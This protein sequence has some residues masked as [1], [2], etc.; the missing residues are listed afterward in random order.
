MTTTITLTWGETVLANPKA[1]SGIK[2]RKVFMGSA[3]EMSDGSMRIDTIGPS[4][5]T[6]KILT[7]I[8]P[9]LTETEFETLETA[10]DAYAYQSTEL[11]LEETITTE[12]SS[13]TTTLWSYNVFAIHNNLDESQWWDGSANAYRNVTLRFDEA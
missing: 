13:T 9:L 11:K 3:S 5:L 1:D 6:K 7:L 10:F 2:A 12:G 8:W 4:A